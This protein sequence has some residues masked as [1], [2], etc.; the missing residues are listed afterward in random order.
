MRDKSM[1]QWLRDP[2]SPRRAAAGLALVVVVAAVAVAV[3]VGTPANKALQVRGKPAAT[4]PGRNGSKLTSRSPGS[5]ADS[6]SSSSEP[7]R[8]STTT[9]SP[10]TVLPTSYSWSAP[11][12]AI[13]P[14]PSGSYNFTALACPSV[15][16]CIASGSGRV[17]FVS[18]DPGGPTPWREVVLPG[19]AI[20]L[21]SITCLS[22][23][24]CVTG[25]SDIY[26]STDPAAGPS[27][28]VP[29]HIHNGNV[30]SLSCPSTHFCMAIQDQLGLIV[31]SDPAGGSSA[32]KS[33]GFPAQVASDPFLSLSCP[34]VSLCVAGGGNGEVAV[35]TDPTGGTS[36]WH[37]FV[38][39][40]VGGDPSIQYANGIGSVT[41]VGLHFCIATDGSGGIITSNDPAG[42]SSAWHLYTVPGV[43]SWGTP[44]CPTASFCGALLD[45]TSNQSGTATSSNP[46]TGPQ[47]WGSMHIDNGALFVAC[48][49]VD[50]CFL[51]KTDGTLSIGT[52]Q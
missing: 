29:Q 48:P 22:P 5:S 33:F 36:A 44:S 49:T 8:G 31:S 4:A 2:G 23:T 12:A 39:D 10:G 35:S 34:T 45:T 37:A 13:P 25:G 30:S 20:G 43:Q 50:R 41:C 32:W 3:F 24:F 40:P 19:N 9:S 7:G 46:T 47:T 15:S 17:V 26:V 16:L 14:P 27:A 51:L 38:I 11:V 6:A 42:G 21:N 28:W 1:P 52:G 18:T